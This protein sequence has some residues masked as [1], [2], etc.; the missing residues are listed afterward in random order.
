MPE[1][2][3]VTARVA[4]PQGV[5]LPRGRTTIDTAGCENV[6]IQVRMVA[7][8]PAAL[9]A[10]GFLADG[11]D[12][13]W[14]ELDGRI[15]R[16]VL[17]VGGVP[18]GSAEMLSQSPMAYQSLDY[19]FAGRLAEFGA[20]TSPCWPPE[21]AANHEPR[22]RIVNSER[23]RAVQGAGRLAA[24]D[25][26]EI[27][28]VLHV[29]SRPPVWALGRRGSLLTGMP[30]I[31]LALPDRADEPLGAVA[32]DA[33]DGAS[34][35]ALLASLPDIAA[36]LPPQAGNRAFDDRLIAPPTCSVEILK[37]EFLVRD[38]GR[39][40]VLAIVDS[41]KGT[42]GTSRVENVP[43]AALEAYAQVLSAARELR[44]EIA[45]GDGDEDRLAVL[46]RDAVSALAALGV[47]APDHW[48]Q[49]PRMAGELED[50]ACL[51]ARTRLVNPAPDAEMEE[52][53]AALAA[54]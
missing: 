25:L 40:S 15:W 5:V 16:P 33:Q 54:L 43:D 48:W 8:A 23:D 4:F 13:V 21:A 2:R 35:E 17:D 38:A 3:I 52:D 26:V 36:G 12:L 32:F 34:A 20:V 39:I 49:W 53:R 6:Q 45:R 22:T 47:Q 46:E 24:R 10:R 7:D 31:R 19:P 42:L 11:A 44:A 1:S 18:L 28:G 9:I 14:R 41:M 50:I 30:E 29:R 51:V 27:G 37:P